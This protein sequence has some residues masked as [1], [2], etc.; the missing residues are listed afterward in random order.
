MSA[1]EEALF[2]VTIQVADQLDRIT[3]QRAFDLYLARI[4]T[5]EAGDQL[6]DWL[7]AERQVTEEFEER[8]KSVN[9]EEVIQ[10]ML[11]KREGT[12]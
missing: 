1:E 5:G 6:G 10:K 3:R 8:L 11:D 4:D 2:N 9:P 7:A 12:M